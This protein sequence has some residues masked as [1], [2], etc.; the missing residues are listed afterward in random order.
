MAVMPLKINR[1]QRFPTLFW[2]VNTL[3][4]FERGAYYGVMGY[5]S[6][7]LKYNLH[8]T[9]DVIGILSAILLALLY[10][11]PI[12]AA[13]FAKKIGYR[14]T[15]LMA[16][17]VLIPAYALMA[18]AH[19]PFSFFFLILIWGI[20]AGA[21]KPM[22]SATI[23]HVTGEE[24]R[25]LAYYIYYLTINLGAFI[26]PLAIGIFIPEAMARFTFILAAVL[27]TVNLLITLLFY[28][29]PVEIDPSTRVGEV[30]VNMARVLSDRKFAVLIAI[31]SGFFMMFSTMH[32]F[33]PLYMKD[34]RLMP[35]WFTTP[36]LATINPLTILVAGPI[37]SKFSS[38]KDS[39][40]LMI[41]G[42]SIFT[43]GLFILGF[44]PLGPAL[45]VGI[46][47]F[48][49]GEFI[50]HPNFISYVSKIAP[51]EKVALYMGYAF[52]PSAIGLVFGSTVGG[53][54]YRFLA[55]EM[56]MPRA[57]WAVFISIG[58]LT[59]FN[60]VLYNTR[61]GAVR[62][63]AGVPAILPNK[64]ATLP[65]LLLIPVVLI[66]S[67]SLGSVTYFGVEGEGAW[68][69]EGEYVLTRVES[70][71]MEGNRLLEGQSATYTLNLYTPSVKS[72]NITIKWVD[73]PDMRR[74]GREYQ[75]QPDYFAAY[76]TPPNGTRI[77][78]EEVTNPNPIG[79]EGELRVTY[80]YDGGE[81]PPYYNATGDYIIEVQMVFAG[82]YRPRVGVIGF[83]DDG[84]DFTISYEYAYYQR[85]D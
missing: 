49:V 45:I 83:Q 79:G 33:L 67:F 53:F 8:F 3:E 44:F 19:S 35:S 32:T 1:L 62:P 73:E 38:K 72:L 50:T 64:S 58:L 48:S 39:L 4:L 14:K 81:R 60:F 63:S 29:D 22:V 65:F 77:P 70:D 2:I 80:V 34:F 47:I 18:Y 66:S 9:E 54:L 76:L 5:F 68:K 57:F 20:G 71:E 7:H 16:F 69:E 6:Y 75:N 42:M 55:V 24:R 61:F 30:F 12:I 26:V 37:L 82:D 13:G 10:F 59:I 15:L 78:F 43:L 25:N 85:V 52:L 11:V 46:I 31:Y 51:S 27:I 56:H 36:L 74:F 21:F 84:N 28:T 23:A 17:A 40:K 41:T